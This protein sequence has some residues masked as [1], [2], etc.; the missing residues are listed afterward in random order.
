M[1]RYQLLVS[2]ISNSV[3]SPRKYWICDLGQRFVPRSLLY[4]ITL[5]SASYP[6]DL[7]FNYIFRGAPTE[8]Q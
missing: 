2:V 6:F 8:L 5:T 1:E 7:T 4:H 3:S